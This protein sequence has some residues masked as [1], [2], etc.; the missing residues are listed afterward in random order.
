VTDI[1]KTAT[2]IEVAEVL[3]VLQIAAP[4]LSLVVRRLAFERDQLRAEL[5]RVTERETAIAVR[6][7]DCER[8]RAKVASLQSSLDLLREALD[9]R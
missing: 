1:T 2:E 9:N 3:R 8:L 6:N 4:T 5:L 7:E